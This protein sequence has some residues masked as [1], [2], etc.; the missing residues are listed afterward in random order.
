MESPTS[1]FY[2]Q[3]LDKIES[4]VRFVFRSFGARFR[5]FSCIFFISLG[6]S[7]DFLHS[8]TPNNALFLPDVPRHVEQV[9]WIRGKSGESKASLVVLSRKGEEGWQE[10]QQSIDVW[11]G[12]NGLIHPDLKREGDG[13]TPLG[14][15]PIE[16]IFGKGKRNLKAFPYREIKKTFHWTD[17]LESRHYNK[18]IFFKE[19]GATSLWNSPLYEIM[20]VVEYNTKSPI[21]GLGS[22]I[23][24]HVWNED[25][26]TSGCIGISKEDIESIVSKLD[27]KKKPH[28]LIE[29]VSDN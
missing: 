22:M 17:R 25:K 26:P 1:S 13:Y 27:A 11:I 14:V 4:F 21:P 8:Q 5:I 18:L 7:P 20:V 29:I 19:R 6:Y 28:I 23:F 3:I 2:F 9:V 12:R 15:Y 16:R 24:I 10:S